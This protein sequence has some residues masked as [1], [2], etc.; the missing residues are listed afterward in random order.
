M[1]DDL[2]ISLIHFSSTLSLPRVI[3]FKF[4]LETHQKYCITQHEELGFSWLTQMKNDYRLANSHYL[5]DTF[6][7]KS[8]GECTWLTW[9][10]N[11]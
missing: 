3:N 5:T 7:F 9:L 1:T 11:P 6:F 4:L 10:G 8:L 2:T